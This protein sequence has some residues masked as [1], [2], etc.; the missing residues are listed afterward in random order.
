M[1]NNDVLR[2]VRY[3][4][5]LDD[6]EMIQTCSSGGI[7]VDRAKISK[8]LKKE[9]DEDYQKCQDFELASFLNGVI[10]GLRGKREGEQPEAEKVLTNNIVLRKI[11]IAFSLKAE[12]VI[13]LPA[14]DELKLSKHELSA[15]FRKPGHKNYRPCKAQILRNCLMGLQLKL[16]PNSD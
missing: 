12:D 8:W 1:H 7:E 10:N 3:I 16:R 13:A 2:R 5:D 15:F 6:T 9:E 11:M 4:L 14:L